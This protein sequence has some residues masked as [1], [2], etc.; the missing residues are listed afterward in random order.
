MM[1]SLPIPFSPSSCPTPISTP[2]SRNMVNATSGTRRVMKTRGWS[3]IHLLLTQE[4][5]E[6]VGVGGRAVHALHPFLQ[7][8]HTGSN[9]ETQEVLPLRTYLA[10]R[11]AVHR[12][13]AVAV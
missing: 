8:L 11:I 6:T 1:A 7:T 13:D 2:A 10:E 9:R 3:A 4:R 5:C 12:S